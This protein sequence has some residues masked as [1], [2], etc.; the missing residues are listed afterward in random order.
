MTPLA[1]GT[2]GLLAAAATLLVAGIVVVALTDGATEIALGGGLIAVAGVLAVSAFFYAVGH[3][4][5]RER[6]SRGPR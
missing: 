5:D 4:E 2:K 3:S 1:R 6:A